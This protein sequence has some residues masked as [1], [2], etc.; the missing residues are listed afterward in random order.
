MANKAT[1]TLQK[2]TTYHHIHQINQNQINQCYIYQQQFPRYQGVQPTF[3]ILSRDNIVLG[4][5]AI[6]S[7]FYTQVSLSHP[8]HLSDNIVERFFGVLQNVK[9]IMNFYMMN[10]F[11]PSISYTS[12]LGNRSV[13]NVSY[14]HILTKPD[15]QST[16]Q[17]QKNSSELLQYINLDSFKLQ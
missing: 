7:V 5:C 13:G 3:G 8:E 15:Y 16:S 17:D 12:G 9:I 6:R 14:I 2:L 4:F 10:G 11:P 1:L